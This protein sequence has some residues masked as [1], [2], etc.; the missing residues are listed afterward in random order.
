MSELGSGEKTEPKPMGQVRGPR[1]G[2]LNLADDTSDG[3][4]SDTH[5]SMPGLNTPRLMDSSSDE[6]ETEARQGDNEEEGNRDIDPNDNEPSNNQVV[7]PLSLARAVANTG[8][9]PLR[10]IGVHH[11]NR[12]G[13][14]PIAHR[15]TAWTRVIRGG[16]TTA[17]LQP[18][19][20][21]FTQRFRALVTIDLDMMETAP[22]SVAPPPPGGLVVVLD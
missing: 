6:L 16:G 17:T 5:S 12:S 7:L 8:E 2:P 13:T 11:L 21:A 22:P 20:T 18:N 9:I 10:Q 3:I 19:D 15:W 4:S 14:L 1:D